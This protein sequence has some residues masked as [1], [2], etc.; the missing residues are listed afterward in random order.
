MV[1]TERLLAFAALSAVLIAIPGPSVLFSVSRALMVGRRGALLTVLGNALGATMQI[2]AVAAGVGAIVQRSVE[3]FTVVKLAGAGYLIFLGVQAIRHR[4]SL[5]DALQVAVPSTRGRRLFRDGFVV[6]LTNP[7]CIVFFVAV[8][9]QFVDRSAGHV[10]VQLLIIG[11]V[12]PA[13]ALIFDSTWALVA[14][15]ARAWF[16]RS[17]QRLA[18]IGGAGGLAMIGIGTRLA[19]T[20]RKD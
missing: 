3:V 2:V 13:I 1:S 8:L 18:A 11:A 4:R 6:G 19:F 10:P 16:V 14:S 20:G 7:K 5:F 15:A 9:P 12:F 17:P